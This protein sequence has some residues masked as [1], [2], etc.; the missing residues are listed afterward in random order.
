VKSYLTS[1]FSF[2]LNLVIGFS[3]LIISSLSF[4]Q[5]L[6]WSFSHFTIKVNDFLFVTCVSFDVLGSIQCQS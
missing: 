6:N 4:T 5:V 3:I 1:K 2:Y